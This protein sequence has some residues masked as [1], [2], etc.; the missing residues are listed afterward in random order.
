MRPVV[1]TMAR[2]VYGTLLTLAREPSGCGVGGASCPAGQR[3]R[4][5]TPRLLL[6]V[7]V[8]AGLLAGCAASD[9]PGPTPPSESAPDG[10]PTTS[11]SA[12][13]TISPEEDLLNLFSNEQQ[14]TD[15][16][17][18][19]LQREFQEGVAECMREAGFDYIPD[20][21][22]QST[23][24]SGDDTSSEEWAATYGFGISIEL[25]PTAPLLPDPNADYVASLSEQGRE[26][27]HI[28]LEGKAWQDGG[29]LPDTSPE[30][31]GCY[32]TVSEQTDAGERPPETP[33]LVQDLWMEISENWARKLESDPRMADA[34]QAVVACV[35]DAG[36]SPFDPLVGESA[37]DQVDR[38]YQELIAGGEPSGAALAQF[39]QWERD[40]AAA[41]YRCSA[42][43]IQTADA[44]YAE[45]VREVVGRERAPPPGRRPPSRA[46]RPRRAWGPAPRGRA[47]PRPAA[48]RRRAGRARRRGHR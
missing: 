5:A 12:A 33:A 19:A 24:S 21:P 6:V 1:R 10:Q 31:M 43:M 18:H 13:P 41:E 11:P 16:Q 44:I 20:V 4:A 8:V 14:L 2:S 34:A 32:V 29:A 38:A 15:E 36:G 39:Q 23:S 40:V 27:Y 28:A 42:E 9:G 3:R 30:S 22:D 45:S 25:V 48:V 37:Y 7:L 47:G 17:T 46:Q 26:A 35:V